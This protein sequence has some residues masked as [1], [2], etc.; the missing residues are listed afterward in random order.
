M[1]TSQALRFVLIFFGVLILLYVLFLTRRVLLMFLVAVI[2]ASAIRPGVRWLQRRG[3]P[4]AAGIGLIYIGIIL[5][6]IVLGIVVLPPAFN[7][8]IGY[9]RGDTNITEQIISAQ[10]EIEAFIESRINVDVTFLSPQ[11]INDTVAGALREIRTRVPAL[12]G[13]VGGLLSDLIL[14]LVIAAYWLASR[15]RA[16]A[17][18]MSL[19][20]TSQRVRAQQ[21]IAQIEVTLGGYVRGVIF[22]GLF[23]GIANFLL[24]TLFRVANAPMLA[25]IIGTTT[26]VPI[27]GGYLGGIGATT[28][29][30]IQSPAAALATLISFLFIQQ[31]ENYV[32][33]PRIMERTI[34]LN[35][36]I[37]I[38]SLLIGF[39]I[40]GIAGG[41]IAVPVAASIQVLLWNLV[42]KPRQDKI[43]AMTGEDGGVVVV[44]E[45]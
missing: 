10:N 30:L 16:V 6:I 3:L 26:M 39:A 13:N 41:L 38:I 19:L 21:I 27:I 34:S 17:Y 25:F 33:T 20:T 45:G 36:V 31:I 8:L 42:I 15:E 35:P 9:V 24:L 40:Y 23:V 28:L 5:V 4:Q 32:L 12:A 11:S 18:L 22:V 7:S 1:T 14:V 43:A 29:A 2:V 44:A 37:T